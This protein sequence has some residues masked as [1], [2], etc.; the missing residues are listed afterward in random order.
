MSLPSFEAHPPS[1]FG[2]RFRDPLVHPT[3]GAIEHREALEP[4]PCCFVV[5]LERALGALDG[6][7]KLFA[8]RL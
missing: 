8:P 4:S 7:E 2:F 3:L 5:F 6:H 1:D